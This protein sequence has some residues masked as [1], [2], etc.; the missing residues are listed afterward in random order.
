MAGDALAA[1]ET[2]AGATATPGARPAYPD[3]APTVTAAGAGITPDE[4]RAAAADDGEASV[5]GTPGHVAVLLDPG[6]L[7]PDEPGSHRGFLIGVIASWIVAGTVVLVLLSGRAATP[8]PPSASPAAT[9]TNCSSTD[10]DR[11]FR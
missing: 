8:T 7:A 3:D 4:L 9:A 11:I 6:D 1:R 2:L 10:G 5:A